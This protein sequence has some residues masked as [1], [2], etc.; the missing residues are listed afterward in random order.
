MN[1]AILLII[2]Y[3][4]SR[5]LIHMTT[6]QYF[7]DFPEGKRRWQ[8]WYY[9]Y[10]PC[11]TILTDKPAETVHVLH[12]APHHHHR[13]PTRQSSDC[14]LDQRARFAIIRLSTE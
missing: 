8:M 1:R 11:L 14:G 5:I 13:P 12:T 7:P 6:L 10:Y 9:L 4:F 2:I 3:Q